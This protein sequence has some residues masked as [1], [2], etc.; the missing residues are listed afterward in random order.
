MLDKAKKQLAALV[1]NFVSLKIGQYTV[2]TRDDRTAGDVLT[3]VS[4]LV[5][6][7][8]S[9]NDG[10]ARELAMKVNN[11]DRINAGIVPEGSIL[12]KGNRIR[13]I[14]WGF[15]I[16]RRFALHQNYPNPFNPTTV[17]EYD[18]PEPAHALLRIFDA[19]GQEVAVLAD[20]Q[21]SPGRYRAQWN[22]SGLSSGVYFCQLRAG[23]LVATR[24]LMVLR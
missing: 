6:D 12:Y 15:D 21:A 7:G 2:V 23:G 24:K 14:V 22:A 13:R 10:L 8:V 11:R 17:I 4:I 16:P 5:S 20:E 18:L 3:Y 9:S 19:L 1:M